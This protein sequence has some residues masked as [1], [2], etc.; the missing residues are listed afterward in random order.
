MRN[1]APIEQE[2]RPLLTVEEQ[3]NHMKSRGTRFDLCSEDKARTFL[4]SRNFYFKTKAFSKNFDKYLNPSAPLFGNYINLDFAYLVELTKLDMHLRSLVLSASLDIEH[5]MK[6]SINADLM[7]AGEDGSKI[8]PSFFEHENRRV[9]KRQLDCFS[10]DEFA[11]LATRCLNAARVLHHGCQE[12]RDASHLL[13]QANELADLV[14]SLT[15][16]TDPNHIEHAITRMGTSTYSRR[17]IA[18]YGN[19]ASMAVWNLLEMVSFGDL[20]A[21]YKYY[22]FESEVKHSTR[23]LDKAKSVKPLLFPA[24]TLRNAAAHNDCLL[25]GMRDRLS[26]PIGSIA[27][28]IEQGSYAPKP[29]IDATKR[30]PIIHDC[31]ALLLCYTA[32]VSSPSIRKARGN[33]LSRLHSRLLENEGYFAKQ[34]EVK[35]CFLML[36][37]LFSSFSK[38]LSAEC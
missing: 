21:F 31:S 28:R 23:E 15:Y 38:I 26:K 10:F 14:R 37:R 5:F 3:I 12:S 17:L 1:S 6:T 8:V 9:R 27:L 36:D 32:L 13:T 20:I 24:K 18:K 33:Q 7:N 25:N 34:A 30:I 16:D 4:T 11:H 2:P 35:G 29:L 19:K 22:F